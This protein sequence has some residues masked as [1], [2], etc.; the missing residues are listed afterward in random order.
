MGTR[1]LIAVAL[2]GE[3][4][5]AQYGQWDGYPSGQGVAILKFLQSVNLGEFREALTKCRWISEEEDKEI[6]NLSDWKIRYPQLSRDCGSD[7][8]NLVLE[9]KNN[10]IALTD[11]I[12]FAGDG[13]FCEY[14]Y[15]ID[16]DTNT[17]ECYEGFKKDDAPEGQRFRGMAKPEAEY[18][19]VHLTASWSLDALPSKE[20]FLNTLE[21]NE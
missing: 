14:A 9:N 15:V 18:G 5:I 8:L 11:S 4:K 19:P 17:F 12:M 2:G 3:Y 13:L 20:E 7:V 6:D 10:D 21:S 1:H 16:L